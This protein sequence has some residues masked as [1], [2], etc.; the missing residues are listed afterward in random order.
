MSKNQDKFN[1][2]VP[3][4]LEKGTSGKGEMKFKGICSSKVED[5]DGETLYPSGFDFQPLLE[6]GFINWNHQAGKD[7]GKI[8]GRPTKLEVINGGNDLYVEGILYPNV[9][10]AQNVFALAKALENDPTGRCLG[11]SIE[12]AALERDPFN[13]KKVLKARL[14]G[15]AITAS[16]KNP[17]T[18][19]SIMKGEYVDSFQDELDLTP[20]LTGYQNF[21]PYGTSGYGDVESVAEFLEREYDSKEVLDLLISRIQLDKAMTAEA[22][23]RVTAKESVEHNP[24]D[25]VNKAEV[26]NQLIS[27]FD[28]DNIEKAK[29]IYSFIE[30]VNN[31]LYNNMEGITSEALQKSFEFLDNQVAELELKKSKESTETVEDE[32][33]EKKEDLEKSEDNMEGKTIAKENL[34]KGMSKDENI[35]DCIRKGLS[36]SESQK[37]VESAITEAED[38]KDRQGGTVTVMELPTVISDSMKEIQT[39]ISEL[40]KAVNILLADKLEKSAVVDEANPLVDLIKSQNDGLNDRFTSI[41][42]ILKSVFESNELIKGVLQDLSDENEQMK[43]T[44]NKIEK[45]SDGP[46]SIT[47][48]TQAKYVDRFEKSEGGSQGGETYSVSDR[49]QKGALTDKLFAVYTDKLSKGQTDTELKKGIE[50]IEITNSITP[51][52]MT[53][54]KGMGINVVR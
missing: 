42:T 34:V 20:Y 27:K 3:I 45:S 26:Y 39:G 37:S 23:D 52:F 19:L 12:G 11:W 41:G 1:F 25:I 50:H 14:S 10:E 8:V 4:T 54:L 13:P 53:R 15:L 21:C 40:T 32:D 22:G 48:R 6:K 16:P 17:N 31:K 18:F 33:K 7:S 29:E 2:F 30:T 9:T 24:K 47:T 43:E 35:E 51:E 46:K 49:N 28:V 38:E 36:L 5:S 44:I